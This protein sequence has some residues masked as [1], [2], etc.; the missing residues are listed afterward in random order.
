MSS[1]KSVLGLY[2]IVYRSLRMDGW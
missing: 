2:R 1:N